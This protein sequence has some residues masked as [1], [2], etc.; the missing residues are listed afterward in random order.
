M[1][2]ESGAVY[3]IRQPE[4]CGGEENHEEDDEHYSE[5]ERPSVTEGFFHWA[6]HN[7]RDRVECYTD[8]RGH[9]AEG[10]GGHHDHTKHDFVDTDIP[11]NRQ[12]N[13]CENQS[14]NRC[15]HKHAANGEE[16][17]HQEEQYGG[18]GGHRGKGIGNGN[19]DIVIYNTIAKHTGE[20]KDDGDN[21]Y[22]FYAVA[23]RLF[24]GFPGEVSVNHTADQKGVSTGEGS[25]LSG[26]HNAE[27]DQHDKKNRE[28]H[29]PD[30]F[31][32]RSDNFLEGG[33]FLVLRLITEVVCTPGGRQHEQHAH[34]NT[35][36]PAGHEE[37]ADRDLA[38]S[39]ENDQ[40][41]AGWNG[42]NN[43]AGEAV[44]GRRP[45]A[46]IAQAQHFRPENTG[47]HGSVSCSRTGNTAHQSAEQTGDLAHVAPHV[48]RA[49]VAETREPFGDAAGVHQ[50]A[51]QNEEGDGKHGEALGGGNR[52]LDQ[53]RQ[54]EVTDQ[55]EGQA[56]DAD[57][58]CHRHA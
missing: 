34:Q 14:N 18:V 6:A 19:G 20:G 33:R 27:T 32:K 55:E 26:A 7:V 49:G 31:K 17:H 2:R 41:H 56:A 58:K 3:K 47:F 45:A 4:D 52:L 51:C 13:R 21:G 43:Q 30:A 50:I 5:I 29:S 44:D 25:G 10:D 24:E 28:E 36:H 40:P 38:D 9:D 8:R 22:V 48:P 37:P 12:Q 42:C 35:G 57:G 39:A 54:W 1:G 16:D 46:R 15:F 11:H 23:E 53:N